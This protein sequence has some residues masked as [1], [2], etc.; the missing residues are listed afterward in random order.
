[1]IHHNH[2]AHNTIS[3]FP[4]W[5]HVILLAV[6][7]LLLKYILLLEICIEVVAHSHAYIEQW[8][9]WMERGL[10]ILHYHINSLSLSSTE[11]GDKHTETDI[12]VKYLSKAVWQ[13]E[14]PPNSVMHG[15]GWVPQKHLM[16][17]VYAFLWHLVPTK[18]GARQW[19]S[20]LAI[21]LH[22][23]LVNIW[24]QESYSSDELRWI[25]LCFSPLFCHVSSLL[26]HPLYF[27][28]NFMA[29]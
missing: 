19:E 12:S 10:E 8:L 28:L 2:L 13:G 29:N 14:M 3:L 25:S 26:S 27:F 22:L 21:S 23:L 6:S 5:F 18:F 9:S 15:K 4:L 17:A 24:R 1:M 7:A 16:E 11:G 20:A